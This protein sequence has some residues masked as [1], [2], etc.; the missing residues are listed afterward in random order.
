M[1]V[2]NISH[3]PSVFIFTVILKKVVFFLTLEFK[4]GH[5]TMSLKIRLKYSFDYRRELMGFETS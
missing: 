4:K 3:F 1:F 5:L 2:L